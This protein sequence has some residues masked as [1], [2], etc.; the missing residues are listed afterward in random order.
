MDTE[1]LRTFNVALSSDQ[2]ID[3]CMVPIGDGLTMARK[4]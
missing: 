3:L 2:R 4:R 1:A